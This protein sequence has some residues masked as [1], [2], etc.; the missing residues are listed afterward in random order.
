MTSRRLVVLALFVASLLGATVS[1]RD[2]FFNLTYL[3][4]GL[5]VFS[6]AWA[7]TSINWVRVTRQTRARR[8]RVGRPLEERFGVTNTGL[9]PKFYLEVR[10][11]SQVPGHRASQVVANLGAR[12]ERAWTVRTICQRRGLYR[13]GPMTLSAGDPFGLFQFQRHLPQT[14]N[15]VVY[16]ASV[17][18][19]EFPLPTGLLPGGEALHR[20]THYVTPNAA[21]VRD[22]APGDSLNRIHWKSTA[23]RE[24]LIVKEFELDPL[25]DIWIILDGHADAQARLPEPE[26]DEELSDLW[27]RRR[28]LRLPPSTEEYGISIAA[29]LAQYFI[30][31][32]R[33]VGLVAYGEGREVVPADRGERQLNKLSEVLAVLRAR[34]RLR[35][36]QVLTIE[37][38]ALARG[39]TVALVTPSSDMRWA[40]AAQMLQRRGLRVVAVCVE[41]AD[42]G[43]APGVAML[44][45]MLQGRNLPAY[46]VRKDDDLAAVLSGRGA[47]AWTAATRSGGVPGFRS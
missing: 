20:R 10:D 42:F 30:R 41:A 18:L 16:P 31:H 39:T 43:G 7:W 35:F 28:S 2:V 24:R 27:L 36:D 45:Q 38:Q 32:D 8:A 11:E 5:L 47:P 25:A 15:V 29:S 3:W 17:R 34:G 37:G 46:L 6:F 23:R 12:Q 21:G 19:A 40:A 33:A 4:G 1:G 44:V 9:I 14:T 26:T 13:L 22:Y